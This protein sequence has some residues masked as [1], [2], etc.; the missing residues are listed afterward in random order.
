MIKLF[1]RKG[2]NLIIPEDIFED[3]EKLGL[4]TEQPVLYNII[5]QIIE[6]K[7]KDFTA[8]ELEIE[9]TNKLNA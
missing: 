7:K 9:I 6:M 1:D 2:N 3:L 5:K 4:Q 8:E